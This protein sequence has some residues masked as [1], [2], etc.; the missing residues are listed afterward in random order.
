MAELPFDVAAPAVEGS[1]R[2]QC[3]GVIAASADAREHRLRLHGHRREYLP[4]ERRAVPGLPVRV[5]APAVGLP[6]R[7]EG[8]RMM[9]PRRNL[10]E[11]H[12]RGDPDRRWLAER[13]L[14]IPSFP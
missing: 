2:G 5:I 12:L 1:C 10:G 3:A 14:A 7:G 4:L 9:R 11:S 13:L 8:A 6:S